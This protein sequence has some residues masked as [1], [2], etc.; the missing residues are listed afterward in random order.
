MEKDFF[1]YNLENNEL[2]YY[3]FLRLN[4]TFSIF[5]VE[6]LSCISPRNCFVKIGF[7]SFWIIPFRF[8]SVN[9]VSIYFVS[10]SFRILQVPVRRVWKYQMGNQN[11]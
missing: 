8:V 1:K 10:I 9:F 5:F 11:P 6:V 4:D 2:F 7:I 3:P